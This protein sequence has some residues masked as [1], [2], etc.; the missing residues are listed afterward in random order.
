MKN[1]I[2][3]KESF[4][5]KEIKK[6]ITKCLIISARDNDLLLKLKEYIKN[7]KINLIF[8]NFYP[9]KEI[10]KLESKNYN[11]LINLSLSTTAKILHAIPPRS[12]NKI[13]YTS[14]SSVY[15]FDSGNVKD[16]FN[17]NLSSSLKIANE[18]LIS[19][20]CIK[21]QINFNILRIFNMYTGRKDEFSI[22]G[23]IFQSLKKNEILN[24]HNNGESIRDFIHIRDVANIISKILRK[25]TKKIILDVGTGKGVKIKDLL[26]YINF[27]KKLIKYNKKKDKIPYS[28]ANIDNLFSDTKF[29][30]FLNID[31]FFEKEFKF[32][33][34]KNLRVLKFYQ[35]NKFKNQNDEYI[36]YGAGNAGKQ[37]Y[38]QLIENKEKVYCFIDDNPNLHNKF[39]RGK[40]ILPLK[41]LQ[42]MSN[43]NHIGSIIISIASL[44]EKKLNKLK[45]KLKKIS[46]NVIYLPTKK[47]LISEKLN[48]NDTMS[49]GIEEIIGRRE[50]KIKNKNTEI[51]GKAI[52]VTG[53]AGSIGSELCRQIEFLKAK[54]IIA[55]DHSEISLFNLKK[56]GLRNTDF[57]LGDIRNVSLINNLIKKNK[58]KHIFH[59]A[60]YKH[61]NILEKNIQSAINNNIIGTYELLKLAKNNNCNFTLISTDK[62]VRA[63]SILGLTKRFAELI[64][65]FF[66]K[67][68]SSLNFNIVRFGN[69]FGSIGSAVPTFIE[70]IN[71]EEI[72]TITD[73]KVKRYFM[74]I[75]EACYLVLE[76]LKLKKQNQTFVLNMGKP[77]RILEII[78]YLINLKKKINPYVN[79]K[80]K[81]TGLK[82]GEKLS[83]QLYDNRKKIFKIN[84]N[85]YRLNDN[86]YKSIDFENVMLKLTRLNQKNHTNKSLSLIKNILKK[87]IKF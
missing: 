78:N 13:I 83:E 75:K 77:I 11:D 31:K 10:S 2:I 45:N 61:L 47:E 44:N 24:I 23:K 12:I 27:P 51:K 82:K 32:N 8:N 76:T 57:V 81:E 62:A 9:S 70:Q 59:A 65:I 53:A 35:L 84:K 43:S 79:Y 29:N 68:N 63:T 20:F 80:I 54:K 26:N 21:N 48:L 66:R 34:E 4:L 39:Y 37:I 18:S 6:K 33:K 36:I 71:K 46:S 16:S 3:G 25:K 55:L 7:G 22:I 41:H 85:I 5:T 72:I 52:L 14:S 73:K 67:H 28:V 38:N 49:M 15:G 42:R 17:R 58:I 69:V 40:K 86:T 50:L 56:I 30:K 87:E 1:I 74:T 60:A 19:N 64:T